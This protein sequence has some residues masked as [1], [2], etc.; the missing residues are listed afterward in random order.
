[1]SVPSRERLVELTGEVKSI[2][3]LAGRE[4]LRCRRSEDEPLEHKPDGSPLTAADLA[5]HRLIVDRLGEIEPTAPVISEEGDRGSLADGGPVWLVDPLDG[6]LG[7]LRDDGQYTVNIALVV[8]G[9]P[10]LGVVHAPGP[11]CIYAGARGLGSHRE[12]PPDDPVALGGELAG[13]ELTAALTN[14]SHSSRM[15][16]FLAECGVTGQIRS[17]SSLKICYVAERR[18]DIYPRFGRTALWDTAAGVAVAREAGCRAEDL[19]GNPL[20]FFPLRDMY[21]HGFAIYD[22]ERVEPRSRLGGR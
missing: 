22:P 11:D 7:Y 15:L 9:D 20:K 17:S 1:M 19:D 13:G 5:A 4:I 10:V 16:N 3:R 14:T 12:C 21:H 18:A 6:T 8:D 2:A